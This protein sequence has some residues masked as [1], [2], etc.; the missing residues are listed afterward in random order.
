MKHYNLKFL[1]FLTWYKSD[2]DIR[3]NL[4]KDVCFSS[5]FYMRD[6]DNR[7]YKDVNIFNNTYTIKVCYNGS[8]LNK[9]LNNQCFIALSDIKKYLNHCKKYHPFKYTIKQNDDFYDIILTVKGTLLAHKFILSYVRY[10]YESPF[11]LYL[12]E[13]CK[14]KKEC[15]EFKN[16]SYLNIFNIVSA[17]VPCYNHGVNIHGIGETPI[18]KQLLTSNQIKQQLKNIDPYAKLNDIFPCITNKQFANINDEFNDNTM[19]RLKSKR[20]VRIPIYLHNYNILKN[21][22]E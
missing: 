16:L 8:Y 19:W 22:T 7:N 2:G 15:E 12:Y 4:K 14:L 13:A 1:N 9:R 6:K 5:I 18:F 21:Y 20:E 3:V 11:S 10:L 17:S